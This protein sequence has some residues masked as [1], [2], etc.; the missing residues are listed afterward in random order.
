MRLYKV[1]K[2]NIDKKG[3]V[4]AKNIK[5]GTRIIR[6]KGKIISN[7]QVEE[8]PKFDNTKDIYLFDLNKRFSLDGDFSWN[9]ARLINHSCSPNCEVEGTGFKIWVTAIRDIK[10]NEELTYDYGF[11]YDSDYK[12]F[13]CKCRSKNCCGYI[14]REESRWRINKKYKK[15][16]RISR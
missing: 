8:N 5:S 4:A 10:K 6:Y 14:V 12:Q 15:S 7:K 9:T 1:I 11:S 2:S 13:P 16:L 3:L